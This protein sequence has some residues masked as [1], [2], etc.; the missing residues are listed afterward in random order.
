MAHLLTKILG[1]MQRHAGRII[2]KNDAI[3]PLSGQVNVPHLNMSIGG[4][5]H[6]YMGMKVLSLIRYAGHP[7]HL[8]GDQAAKMLIEAASVDHAAIADL[9]QR[10]GRPYRR[11][12]QRHLIMKMPGE[13]PCD[14]T[15][16]GQTF[17]AGAAGHMTQQRTQQIPLALYGTN[18]TD[19]LPADILL[20]DQLLQPQL[21]PLQLKVYGILKTG[22]NVLLHN[23]PPLF[24]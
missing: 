13:P 23:F 14:L 24:R 15:G 20:P 5:L 16:A 18:H 8:L 22:R 6:D 21:I 17:A 2:G 10:H 9:F 7:L 12:A 4:V 11:A 3:G 1:N 19:L